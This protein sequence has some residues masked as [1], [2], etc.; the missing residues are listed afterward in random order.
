LEHLNQRSQ[1]RVGRYFE[2]LWFFFLKNFLNCER[3]E[4]G[5]QMN[6]G[7]NTVGEC[8]FLL[9]YKKQEV[10]LEVAVKFFLRVS[11]DQTLASYCGPNAGDRLDLKASKLVNSQL[12]CPLPASWDQRNALRRM[13]TRGILFEPY[14]TMYDRP[15]QVFE[16]AQHGLWLAV[17][18]PLWEKLAKAYDRWRV[19]P[20]MEWLTVREQANYEFDGATF[21]DQ[22]FKLFEHQEARALYVEGERLGETQRLFLA[23]PAWYEAALA[24]SVA[25]D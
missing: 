6:D 25:P 8:D 17:K 24:L 19:V 14:D 10:H 1:S 2:Q 5:V 16:S 18:D 13:I 9:E 12:S 4:Q 15:S 20:R 23:G 7:R 21:W 3:L 22:S 11:G